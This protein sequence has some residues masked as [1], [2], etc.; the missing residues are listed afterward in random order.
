[1][2]EFIETLLATLKHPLRGAIL[3][4]LLKGRTTAS[5]IAANLGEKPDKIYYH[6]KVLKENDFVGEPEVVVRKNYVEKYYELNPQFRENL[7]S[8]TREIVDKEQEMSP[9]EFKAFMLSFL[10]MAISVLQGYKK[11]LENAPVE[12]IEEIQ[13]KDNFE[14]KSIFF[15]DDPY[16]T[17][18]KE[19]RTVSHGSLI[20]MFTEGAEGNLGLLIA[21]PDLD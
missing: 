21:L 1:M 10:S 16:V 15:K 2:S 14:V 7:L 12:K 4:Q 8:S 20:D 11:R 19:M 18:L 6:L 13:K 5:Q 17:W 3:Y 9:E